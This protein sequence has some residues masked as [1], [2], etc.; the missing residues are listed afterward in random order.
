MAN[1]KLP[2]AV[3]LLGVLLA[4]CSN[5]L[6]AD[7][8]GD[9]PD[10]QEDL[11]AAEIHLQEGFEGHW[12]SIELNG[13]VR[14]QTRLDS[15]VPFSGPLAVF[16]LDVPLGTHQLLIRWVPTDGDRQACI[17]SM[18]IKLDQAEFYYLGLT[19]SGNSIKVEVQESPFLYV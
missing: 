15:L 5:A 13:K 16:R 11:V 4:G 10:N 17:S 6:D 8:P 3:L 9:D 12:V 18:N 7:S 19:A 2:A 1:I 14:F